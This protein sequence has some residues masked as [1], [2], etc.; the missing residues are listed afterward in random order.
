MSAVYELIKREVLRA[1][2]NFFIGRLFLVL[3]G[4]VGMTLWLNAIRQSA[5]LWFVWVLIALQLF[6]YFSIFVC[7]I[8]R[9]KQC[10][11]RHAFWPICVLAAASRVNDWELVLI[12]AMAVTML[13]LSERNQKV[14]AERQYLLPEEGDHTEGTMDNNI[15]PINKEN[16]IK[17]W[18]RWIA[19][20]P[21]AVGAYFGIQV[22]VGLGSYFTSGMDV[23]YLSQLICSIAGPYCLVWVGAKT[24]PR[25]RFVTALALAIVH[26]V[27]NVLIVTLAV[28]FAKRDSTS[29]WWIVVCGIAGVTASIV[30][31]IQFRYKASSSCVIKIRGHDTREKVM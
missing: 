26:A 20:L 10:G 29:I 25:Y 17:E 21:A 11:Y 13:V 16:R 3:A 23:D 12:P 2:K 18:L 24:A 14:S 28:V 15:Q 30:A 9:A 27:A 31:C 5:A 1:E 8:M 6:L 22:L 19:V 4:Y 7:C